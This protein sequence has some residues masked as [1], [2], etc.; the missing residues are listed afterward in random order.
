MDNRERLITFISALKNRNKK[1]AK[2]DIKKWR[3]KIEDKVGSLND[4]HRMLRS[5]KDNYPDKYKNFCDKTK[6]AIEDLR[7]ES[8]YQGVAGEEQYQGQPQD[9]T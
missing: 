3:V 1:S 5:Y 4:I 7:K 6:D 8:S 2:R 9:Y